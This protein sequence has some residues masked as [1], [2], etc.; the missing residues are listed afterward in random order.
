[1]LPLGF[2]SLSYNPTLKSGE[3]I[4][5]PEDEYILHPGTSHTYNLMLGFGWKW[6]VKEASILGLSIN[7]HPT[8]TSYL[9]GFEMKDVA[10]AASDSYYGLRLTYSHGF[11]AN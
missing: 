9:E 8:G 11:F 1:M 4:E 3:G 6:R 10:A 5:Y 7:Y 2:G